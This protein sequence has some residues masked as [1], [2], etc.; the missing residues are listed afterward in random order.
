M[1]RCLTEWLRCCPR[2][3]FVTRFVTESINRNSPEKICHHIRRE[4]SRNRRMCKYENILTVDNKSLRHGMYPPAP[5]RD[6]IS[7]VCVFTKKITGVA[8]Y[9]GHIKLVC[10]RH[11]NTLSANLS[12]FLE[13]KRNICATQ[14]HGHT[15][16]YENVVI[17]TTHTKPKQLLNLFETYTIVTTHTQMCFP[18]ASGT[19]LTRCCNTQAVLLADWLLITYKHTLV[20]CQLRQPKTICCQS[21]DH[22]SQTELSQIILRVIMDNG[23]IEICNGKKKENPFNW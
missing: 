14:K 21:K 11:K 9:V 12:L 10:F 17:C 23:L 22:N 18:A 8:V 16:W 7:Q 5:P 13:T 2:E 19:F 3:S 20:I 4:E 6:S 15:L 1:C